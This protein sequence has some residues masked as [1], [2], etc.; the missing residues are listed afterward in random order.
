MLRQSNL[1]KIFAVDNYV[2]S[3]SVM[4]RLST[5]I[6]LIVFTVP[7]IGFAQNSS[8][9][10]LIN[11]RVNQ[12]P[13]SLKDYR[14]IADFLCS[15]LPNERD[16]LTA[17]HSWIGYNI[18]YDYSQLKEDKHF[19]TKEELIV[20]VLATQQAVCE[21]YSRL[22]DAMCKSQGIKS[23]YISGYSRR[24]NGNTAD[25]SHAWNG[26]WLSSGECL[27]VDVTWDAGY[28]EN[29]EY[30]FEYCDFYFLNEPKDF[31][32]THVPF[33]PIWQFLET[34]ISHGDL[35]E[36]DFGILNFEGSFNFK[37]SINQLKELDEFTSVQNEIRR[38][39]TFGV[40]NHLIEEQL[41]YLEKRLNYLET[42]KAVKIYNEATVHLNTAID[43][44]NL[45]NKYKHRKFRKPKISDDQILNM[46]DNILSEVS[47]AQDLARHVSTSD[48]EL[49]RDRDKILRI[50]SRIEEEILIERRWVT[51]RLDKRRLFRS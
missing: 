13:D 20:D 9:S 44:Y 28:V 42:C 27:M 24:K 2:P 26:V 32:K 41:G 39:K 25:L 23:F 17:I 21:G 7:N 35:M 43:Q 6:F 1:N 16:K 4:Y 49:S 15:E 33:D 29:G 50:I 18:K 47:K 36:N 30:V 34:P 19:E 31:I 38:I 14:D 22:F 8:N 5:F 37:D 10:K 40:T 48:L 3:T 45:Y 46:V 51:K 12:V 11:D